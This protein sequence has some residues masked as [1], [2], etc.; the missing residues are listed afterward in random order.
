MMKIAVG[1]YWSID[2]HEMTVTKIY[3]NG[4]CQITE[5]WIAEDTGEECRSVENY[6]I[7]TEGNEQYAYALD[8]PEYRLYVSGA[9]NWTPEMETKEE[10]NEMTKG[11]A[12]I[13][14]IEIDGIVY[15][16]T[17]PGYYYKKVDGKQTRI[18]KAEWDP[19][20]E[21]WQAQQEAER[22][23]R[24]QA[25]KPEE[26]KAGKKRTRKSKDV[27]YTHTNG[28]TL[29]TKQAEFIMH[30]PDTC[31]YEHGL[32]S[33]VWCDVLADEIGGQFTGKPMTVGAM[34]STLREKHLIYVATEKVN[35]K[36]AKYFGFTDLGKEVA[37]GLGLE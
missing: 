9:I 19:V 5:T 12:Q 22:K 17:R 26:K 23:E 34:I 20:F 6:G 11:M 25:D 27:M 10:E 16:S 28:L 29:T 18:P 30:I 37:K 32:E 24:E 36:K 15:T 31:F 21:K 33:T 1:L 8:N 3:K 7:G 2:W 14:Q 35:G 4:K 13:T